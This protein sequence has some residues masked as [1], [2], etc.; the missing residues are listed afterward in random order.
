MPDPAR[1]SASK[2]SR[3]NDTASFQHRLNLICGG[4]SNLSVDGIFGDN[5]ERAIKTYRRACGLDDDR[6]VGN[7]TAT[8]MF[9]ELR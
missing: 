1:R 3:C 7:D 9:D 6:K 8:R 4:R 5:A 2:G